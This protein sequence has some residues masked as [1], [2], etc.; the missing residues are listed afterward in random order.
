M[1]ILKRRNVISASLQIHNLSKS[2]L[3]NDRQIKHN[4]LR[5]FTNSK[6]LTNFNN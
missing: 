3:N 2:S 1:S 5:K 4:F 6:D